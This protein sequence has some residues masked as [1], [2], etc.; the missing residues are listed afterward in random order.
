MPSL[1]VLSTEFLDGLTCHEVAPPERRVS[2]IDTLTL[3]QTEYP[4]DWLVD[5]ILVAGQP[6]IVGGAKKVLK[7]SILVDLAFALGTGGSFLGRFRAE[8]RR[9]VGVISGESGQATLQETYRRVRQSRQFPEQAASTSVFWSF[10]LPQ[11]TSKADLLDL[12]RAITEHALEV[13]VFDPLYLA[14]LAGNS[15]IQASNLYQIGPLLAD[16]AQLCLEAGATPIL[17]H[18]TRKSTGLNFEPAEL[19]DLAFAGVQEYAR[20][21]WLIGRREKY[22]PG[23]G[24]HKIWLNIGGSVGFSGLWAVDIDEGQVRADFG[25]RRWD[26]SVRSATEERTAQQRQRDQRQTEQD[27]E[28]RQRIV[29]VLE[30]HPEGESKSRIGSLARLGRAKVDR[31][32]DALIEAGEVEETTVRRAAGGAGQRGYAGYKLVDNDGEEVDDVTDGT[33]E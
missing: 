13:V 10:R 18:H 16:V 6:A 8:Q 2:F 23:T 24:N 12:E 3:D 21:W 4:L 14:L 5:G 25:G 27:F 19:E 28:E 33:E 7:T 29:Q 22:Q 20:Q 32:L 30:R 1:S 17:A 11:L 31:L 26:V 15:D 9:R